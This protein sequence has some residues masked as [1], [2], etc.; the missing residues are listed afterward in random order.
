MQINTY[1]LEVSSKIRSMI[2]EEYKYLHRFNQFIL[3]LKCD[4]E[5]FDASLDSYQVTLTLYLQDKTYT[6]ISC[7]WELEDAVE[8]AFISLQD[9]LM[10][11]QA[12]LRLGFIK[13]TF[14]RLWMAVSSNPHSVGKRARY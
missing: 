9:K 13:G 14:E 12:R 4:I 8:E 6:I 5:E 2:E 11:Q 1:N 3:L 10:R 7:D